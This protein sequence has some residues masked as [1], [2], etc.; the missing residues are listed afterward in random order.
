VSLPGIVVSSNELTSEALAML[1]TVAISAETSIGTVDASTS[2]LSVYALNVPSIAV[3]SPGNSSS[4]SSIASTAPAIPNTTAY[5]IQ[6]DL[7]KLFGFNNTPTVDH[8][9]GSEAF[10][11]APM[12]SRAD[13]PGVDVAR[14]STDGFCECLVWCWSSYCQQFSEQQ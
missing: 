1:P 4:L 10:I 14:D 11:S 2:P 9:A 8:V 6:S 3:Q 12:R 13:I 5:P 7:A